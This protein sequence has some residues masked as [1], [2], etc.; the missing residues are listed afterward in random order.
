MFGA[1]S[2]AEYLRQMNELKKEQKRFDD[3]S[4][5]LQSAVAEAKA[6]LSNLKQK[7]PPSG[8]VKN[9]NKETATPSIIVMGAN[10]FLN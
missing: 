6:H 7:S 1:Y 8:D 4:S 5:K 2:K 3:I 9:I 10:L